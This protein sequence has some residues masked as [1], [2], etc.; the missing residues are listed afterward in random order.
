MKRLYEIPVVF[1]IL[2]PESEMQQA[3]DQVVAWLENSNEIENVG[4]VVKIDRTKLG[5]RRLAY[6]IK[7]Q[8]DGLYVLI[9]AELEPS[10][11]PEFE[12]NMRLFDPVLRYLIIRAEEDSV[13]EDASRPKPTYDVVRDDDDDDN[14][15]EFDEEDEIL[16]A[17][18]SED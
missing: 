17:T 18:D 2:N 5:R 14:E 9:Y 12:L 7:G 15:D 4:K 10:H 1:R 3:I 16:E 8:R 13:N 11:L 6:E